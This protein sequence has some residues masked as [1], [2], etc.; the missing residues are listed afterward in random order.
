MSVAGS[1]V[2]IVTVTGADEVTVA[3]AAADTPEFVV[4][5]AVIATVSPGEAVEGAV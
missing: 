3:V 4:D 1:A 5:F 2:D